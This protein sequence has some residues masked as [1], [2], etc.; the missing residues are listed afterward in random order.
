MIRHIVQRL[1]GKLAM[2]APG[3]YSLRPWLQR[4]RGVRIGKRVWISQLV[5]LDEAHPEKIVIGDDAVI[6]FRCTVFA[7]F[8]LGDRQL[9][10][11]AGDVVIGKK[12]FIGPACTILSGVTVGEGAVVVAGS[13]LTR[14][15]PAGV[16]Y[17]P[18]APAPLARITQP[19]TRDGEVDYRR[20][21]FGLRKM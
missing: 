17:G 12:A 9:D 1:L 18:P 8:Y 3:G 14:N 15:V 20:F 2:V 4:M 10:L 6:G 7:H 16:L 13:V 21:I 5:Y 19:L 11:E